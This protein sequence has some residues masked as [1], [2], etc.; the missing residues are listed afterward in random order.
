MN[1]HLSPWRTALL[2]AVA[3]AVTNAVILG[4][5]HLLGAD[6]HVAPTARATET[7]VGVGSVLLVSVAP[8]ILGGMT[9]WLAAPR[10]IRPWRAV[11]WLGLAL[12][13]LTVPLPFAVRASAETSVSLSL[14]HV[15]AGVVWF[16]AIRRAATPTRDPAPIKSS[17]VDEGMAQPP[18]TGG[19]G[20]PSRSAQGERP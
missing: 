2:A 6:M 3:T 18:P 1:S 10:G 14:M 19:V 20:A 7:E 8:M 12:G 5:A 16:A 11:G 4:I 9:L 13:L 17:T 15:V